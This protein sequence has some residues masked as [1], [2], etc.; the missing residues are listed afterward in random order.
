MTIPAPTMLHLIACVRTKEYQP[1]ARYQDNEQL[2]VDLAMAYQKIIQA[3]YD[4]G[5]RYLQLDDTSWGEFCSKEKREE[6]AN[7]GIDVGALVKNMYI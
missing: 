5:C 1:I 3:F 6:Y 2:I 7:C 4:R